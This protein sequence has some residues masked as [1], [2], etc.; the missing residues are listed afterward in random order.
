M[1]SVL[2]V[3]F[4]SPDSSEDEDG[5]GSHNDTANGLGTSPEPQAKKVRK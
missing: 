1:F 5:D 4:F 2:C 3:F